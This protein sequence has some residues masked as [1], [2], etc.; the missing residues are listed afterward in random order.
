MRPVTDVVASPEIARVDALELRNATPS[1]LLAV[2]RRTCYGGFE[3]ELKKEV[4]QQGWGLD[5]N[6]VQ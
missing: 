2:S 6:P 1:S 3:R 4:R 5:P